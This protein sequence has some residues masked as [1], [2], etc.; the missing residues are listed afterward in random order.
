M[1]LKFRQNVFGDFTH[2]SDIAE[3]K[4][5]RF[6]GPLTP[7][8]EVSFKFSI[9]IIEELRPYF[10]NKE[11]NVYILKIP[12]DFYFIDGGHFVICA[13]GNL[14]FFHQA[15]THFRINNQNPF[16]PVSE[17]KY[18]SWCYFDNDR[19]KFNPIGGVNMQFG[20]TT[21]EEIAE[22]Q[23]QEFTI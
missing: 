18:Y 14:Y 10:D 12:Y 15:I 5:K 11:E 13:D 19:K 6:L 3:E 20:L 16:V 2:Y 21:K 22:K 23:L 9:P 7:R 4:L 1:L 17:I 8:D